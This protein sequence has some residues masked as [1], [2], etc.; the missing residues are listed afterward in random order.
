M[1]LIILNI[2]HETSRHWQKCLS[3]ASNFWHTWGKNY[4]LANSGSEVSIYSFKNEFLQHT[5]YFIQLHLRAVRYYTVEFASK[6]KLYTLSKKSHRSKE[7]FSGSALTLQDSSCCWHAIQFG[8]DAKERLRAVGPTHITRKCPSAHQI[9]SSWHPKPSEKHL[10][11]KMIGLQPFIHNDNFIIKHLIFQ[12][13]KKPSVFIL[14][15]DTCASNSSTSQS[16]TGEIVHESKQRF[17]P[18]YTCSVVIM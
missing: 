15:T 2:N 12:Q 13:K 8:T 9:T 1:F 6:R 3:A 10:K 11:F 4:S 18:K 17:T 5:Q 7:L 14:P 16:R